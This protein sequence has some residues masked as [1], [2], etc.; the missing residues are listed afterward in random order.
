MARSEGGKAEPLFRVLFVRRAL[1]WV[2]VSLGLCGCGDGV[3]VV[4]G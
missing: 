4:G 2:V 1:P 3:V